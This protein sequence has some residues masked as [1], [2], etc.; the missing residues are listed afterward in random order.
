MGMLYGLKASESVSCSYLN[1]IFVVAVACL[2]ILSSCSYEDA[3]SD[4][5]EILAMMDHQERCW[6]Q[7]DVE[8]FME[9]YWPS[10]S[11]MFIGKE[12]VTY[13][14]EN[15]LQR[16]RNNYPDRSAMGML[17]FDIVELQR[18]SPEAYYMVGKWQLERTIGDI[19]GHFTLLFRKFDG[20]WFIVKDH[21]S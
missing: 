15:T 8:C 2:L 17:S 13:G 19:G 20:Q 11:L 4:R 12:G 21:S 1:P 14:Y 5:A 10:D 18:L 7:G 3:A 6:N 16:Y 9:G